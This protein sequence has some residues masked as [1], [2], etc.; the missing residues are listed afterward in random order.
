MPSTPSNVPTSKDIATEFSQLE[1]ISLENKKPN[2][3]NKVIKLA[4]IIGKPIFNVSMVLACC[5]SMAAMIMET[6]KIPMEGITGFS[7]S[8]FLGK[9]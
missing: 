7:L 5:D 9:K 6:D 4:Q 3:R 2:D 1:L 8:I